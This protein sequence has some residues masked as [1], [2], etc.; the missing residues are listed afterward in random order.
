MHSSTFINFFL[1]FGSYFFYSFFLSRHENRMT[2]C[3]GTAS[4][5]SRERGRFHHSHCSFLDIFSYFSHYL[6][7]P[8]LLLFLLL[9]SHHSHCS[10]LTFFSYF[11]HY[12]SLS[13]N[14]LLFLLLLSSHHSHCSFLTFFLISHTISH[15]LP[16]SSSSFSSSLAFT[17]CV[18]SFHFS[19]FSHTLSPN[20][21]LLFSSPY[22]QC[23]FFTFFSLLTHTLSPNLFPLLL[24]SPY[25]QCSFFSFFLFLAH[26]LSPSLFLLLS[27]LYSQ[28]FLFFLF[29]TLSPQSAPSLQPLL[30][31]FFHFTNFSL[32]FAGHIFL[33]PSYS[34]FNHSRLLFF[35]FFPP[36]SYL[37]FPLLFSLPLSLSLSLSLLASSPSFILHILLLHSLHYLSL[38]FTFISHL[39]FA[40]CMCVTTITT[41]R[42]SRFLLVQD[43]RPP[44]QYFFIGRWAR[45]IT[46]RPRRRHKRKYRGG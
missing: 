24:S 13:P 27:S 30:S 8:I 41:L 17:L 12:L 5:Q 36:T 19:Y 38:S 45:V 31:V 23:S 2:G 40:F 33:L 6:S 3:R 10:F 4:Y 14:L 46:L 7:L 20:H 21:F 44:R 22:S 39:T 11:S 18:L 15:S 9:S 25:S 1:F 32:S 28:C 37:A 35:L 26:T 43:S 29:L 16:I 34:F 42:D